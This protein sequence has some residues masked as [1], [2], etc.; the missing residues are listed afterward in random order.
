MSL[1]RGIKAPHQTEEQTKLLTLAREMAT[2]VRIG[3]RIVT[4]P[5]LIKQMNDREPPDH[6]K[7]YVEY[8]TRRYRVTVEAVV[9]EKNDGH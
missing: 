2:G 4:E 8:G 7:F 5:V 6:T 1:N 9:E 3:G